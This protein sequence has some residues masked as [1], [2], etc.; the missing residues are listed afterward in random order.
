MS[1]VSPKRPLKLDDLDQITLKASEAFLAMGRFLLAYS[2]RAQGEGALAT[3]CSDIA[4]EQDR[5]SADPA[6]LSDWAEC[7]HAVL[8][9]TKE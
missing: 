1:E 3:I 7:V 6:A 2:E 5:M 4:I 8:E 9:D